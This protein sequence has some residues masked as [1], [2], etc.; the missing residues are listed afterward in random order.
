MIKLKDILEESKHKQMLNAGIHRDLL[1][2]DEIIKEEF[3]HKQLPIHTKESREKMLNEWKS[4]TNPNFKVYH[5]RELLD[6]L[7]E[8]SRLLKADIEL[9]GLD[10]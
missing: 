6:R 1:K 5:G 8:T 9:Y 7:K 2:I 10:N 3:P 4:E